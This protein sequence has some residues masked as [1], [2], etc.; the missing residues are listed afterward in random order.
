MEKQSFWKEITGEVP[1]FPSLT[2]HIETEI[3][4]I[5]GGITGIT[6]ALQLRKAGHRVVVLEADKVGGGTT[7]YSTG[8]LYVPV[9]PYYQT[10]IN[11]FDEKI[12]A[13]VAHARKAAIDF[14]EQT[15]REKSIECQFHRRPFY[16]YVKDEKN[17]PKLE[18]EVSALQ[19]AGIEIDYTYDFPLPEDYIKAARIDN[20]A[21][22]NPY[23]YVS[24]LASKLQV[25]GC[26]IFEN[27]RV[28]DVKEE[29]RCVVTTTSGQVIADKVI[30]AT[31][32][33]KGFNVVQTLVG[34]YRSYV[35]AVSLEG[36]YPDGNFWDLDK[37]PAHAI[38]SHSTGEKLDML[39]FAGNHHKTGQ[40]EE[41]HEKNY[42]EI[43]AY[44]RR[45]YKVKSI[46][47]Q[48]SAQHYSPADGLPY[49]GNSTRTTDRIYMATGF[50]ADGLTYGTVAG[51]LLADLIMKKENPWEKAFS[52]TRFTPLASAEKFIKEN[53]NVAKEY[54]KDYTKKQDEKA[55]ASLRN[56]DAQI[57]ELDG[58]K[59]AAHRDEHGKMH[60]VSAVCTHL[61]CIVHFND[62]E[63]TWDCPCHGSRFGLDGKVIEGPA[64]EPL[65]KIEVQTI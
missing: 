43:E 23:E 29:E 36:D 52:S 16:Y 30:M 17:L 9:Q 20:Q 2:D 8:N 65:P 55:F 39:M 64:Y 61:G 1:P 46:G 10:I 35:V 19:K 25:E 6:A 56:G 28:T 44:I 11:K 58:G 47:Y 12:A 48:W 24:A 22:F 49:I 14:V 7:G 63:K 40:A 51:I 41:S 38:S 37:Q 34:P 42:A 54:A 21:R 27:S 60:V 57:L 33:P 59:V 4:I 45:Y 3:A 18:R 50:S 62:A 5:G 32:T 53:L 13:T 15:A 26:Q 31:H